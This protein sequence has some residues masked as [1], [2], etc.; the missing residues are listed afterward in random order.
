[1]TTILTHRGLEPGNRD[2]PW[3]E[4]TF[5][6]FQNH[7]ERGFGIEFDV[8]GLADGTILV[9]HDSNL[10]RMSG[11]IDRREVK[12][13]K[14]SDVQALDYVKGKLC[15]L[16]DLFELLIGTCPGQI[17][18]MHIK[19]RCQRQPMLDQLCTVL[20]KYDKKSDILSRIM[21][22]DLRQDSA[23]YIRKKLPSVI[24]AASVCDYFDVLRYSSAV[25]ETLLRVSDIRKQPGLFQWAWLDEWDTT[26][27]DG[28]SKKFY[29]ESIFQDIRS[30]GMFIAVVS[31]ELHALSPGLLGG[32]SH[33]DAA[34]NER[35]FKRMN[36]I[37][38]LQPDAIC[39]DYP[40][41]ARRLI[42]HL[43]GRRD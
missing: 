11:G 13:L 35:L 41:E 23:V 28:Q 7:L 26:G 16:E 38:S 22:F 36:E 25:G 12:D 9:S 27:P 39:T 34:S 10:S 24:L 19:D 43:N 40:E 14:I 1:M 4:S 17:N 3:G 20:R 33:Q 6:A 37:L 30:M 42:S 15:T 18:A 21:L 29:T 8:I 2:F 5:E 32:E 31:P